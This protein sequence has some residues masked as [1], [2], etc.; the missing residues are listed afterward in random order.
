MITELFWVERIIRPTRYHLRTLLD[1]TIYQYYLKQLLHQEC[2]LDQD[3]LLLKWDGFHK[4]IYDYQVTD[5]VSL[6]LI[7]N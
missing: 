6:K 1:G 3:M 7:I 4:T 2:Y 5:A